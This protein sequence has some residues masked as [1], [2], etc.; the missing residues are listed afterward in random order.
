MFVISCIYNIE[1]GMVHIPHYAL[2]RMY[3]LYTNFELGCR[4]V[5]F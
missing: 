1:I 2:V 4:N 5:R 3:I